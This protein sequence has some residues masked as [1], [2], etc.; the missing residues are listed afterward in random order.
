MAIIKRKYPVGIQS[1]ER[2]RTESYLYVDKTAYIQR[3]LDSGRYYFLSRPR[4]FGKSLLIST[5]KCFFEGRKDL[6]EGLAIY[7]SCQEWQS[8]EVLHID[9]SGG[10]YFSTSDLNAYIDDLL[11]EFEA[12][13]GQPHPGD[14]FNVRFKNIIRKAYEQSGREV[15]VLIDE[16]DAPLFDSLDNHSLQTQM[17]NIVRNLLSP[18]KPQ[19]EYIRFILISGITKFSQMSVFSEL[20]N[21]TNISMLPQYEGICGI[22]EEE[23]TT[24]LSQ[25]I[26]NLGLSLGKS[27]EE[28]LDTLKQQYDGYHFC[29]GLTDIY[30]PYSLL[31]ALNN[32][33]ISNYWFASGTPSMLLSLFNIRH[34]DMTELEGVRTTVSRFDTPV[35]ENISDPI[36]MLF[37]SGYLT[38]KDYDEL[39]SVYTLGFP[40][41]EVRSGYAESLFAHTTDYADGENRRC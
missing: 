20:N 11:R 4:R 35:E 13:Y 22:T 9:F 31:N 23:L 17:R 34:M 40:N 5:L 41:L 39:S 14:T 32:Q 18:L 2:L 33:K 27:Y 30:N 36:P 15:V 38:I 26:E 10:K 25:D 16:Y 3:L 6:F 12:K 28:A 21:L 7:E 8:Y 29:E 1:F 24:Q 37:Q 19:G